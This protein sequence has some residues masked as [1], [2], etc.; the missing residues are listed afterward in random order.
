M[1]VAVISDIHG[2]LAALEAVLADAARRG[3]DRFLCLGDVAATGPHPH[4]VVARVRELGCLVVMGNTDAWLLD[5]QPQDFGAPELREIDHWCATQL[6]EED[7]E[8][9]RAYQPTVALDLDDVRVLAVHGSPRSF[10][11]H[12]LAT[13]P[14][15]QLD[16]MLVGVQADLVL[17]GHTHQAMIRRH[18]TLLLVNPGSVGMAWDQ[19]PRQFAKLN[20][21]WAEYAVLTG[22]RGRL[23]I[24]LLRVGLERERVV[25]P[26]LACGMPHAQEWAD[27]WATE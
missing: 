13:T 10:N 15:E 6:T 27:G 18:R 20:P 4:A 16:D 17:S 3:I 9:M 14:G 11:E 2:N 8:T 5:P 7:R 25:A 19:A 12:T 22:E 23:G 21:L 1:Q 26:A 24:E